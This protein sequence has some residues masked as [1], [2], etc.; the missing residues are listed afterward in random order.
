MVEFFKIKELLSVR[1]IAQTRSLLRSAEILGISQPN[2]SRMISM[3][4]D[5]LGLRIFD[6]TSRPLK[7]TGFG[8]D[9]LYYIDN[10]L[11]SHAELRDFV[12]NYKES[13]SGHVRLHAPVGHLYFIAKHVAPYLKEHYPNIRLELLT[14]NLLL[15]EYVDGTKFNSDCDILFT[16]AQ[17][18]DEMLVARKLAP[19]AM[20]VYATEDFIRQHPVNNV[21]DYEKYPCI[22]FYHF[23]AGQKNIWFFSDDIKNGIEVSINGNYVCDNALIAVGLT[24]QGLGYCFLPDIYVRESGFSHELHKSLPSGISS[25]IDSYIIYHRRNHLPHRVEIVISAIRDILSGIVG[26]KD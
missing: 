6:R 9:F 24:K 19:M 21:S 20:N 16:H 26:G 8:E 15:R 25:S 10:I 17:P 7:L 13:K 3:I 11:T 4:E 5:D 22:L 12:D 2:L 23:M 1:H 18:R 14:N